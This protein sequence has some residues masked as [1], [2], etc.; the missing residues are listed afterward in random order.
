MTS[1]KMITTGDGVWHPPVLTEAE[2]TA[3]QAKQKHREQLSSAM[4]QYLLKGYRMLGS[5]CAICG[6][7]SDHEADGM[8][9]S[10]YTFH[11]C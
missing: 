1:E 5:N 4:G 8:V 7:R 6:V 11:C 10:I 3:L 9:S 2:K